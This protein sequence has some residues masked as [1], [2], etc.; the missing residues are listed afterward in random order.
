[1][2]VCAGRGVVNTP[3]PAKVGVTIY[4]GGFMRDLRVIR[5]VG[6]YSPVKREVKVQV[7]HENG[8]RE[9]LIFETLQD[10]VDALNC[11]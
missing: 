11:D 9:V 4:F 2:S 6:R 3:A 8:E 5:I 7:E 10:A 1:M